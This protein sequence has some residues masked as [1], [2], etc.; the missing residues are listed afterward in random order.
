MEPPVESK[1]IKPKKRLAK[2]LRIKKYIHEEKV[3]DIKK[4]KERKEK[5]KALQALLK[6][7]KAAHKPDG[8]VE[9]KKRRIAAAER[10]FVELGRIVVLKFGKHAGTAAMIVDIVDQ[11]WVMVDGGIFNQKEQGLAC[12]RKVVNLKDLELTPLQTKITYRANL[13]VLKRLVAK[14]KLEEKWK[15][16]AKFQKL[17]KRRFKKN[18]TDLERWR[19]ALN[20]KQRSYLITTKYFK[21]KRKVCAHALKLY[22]P[23][24]P[25][26]YKDRPHPGCPLKKP[27]APRTNKKG[28]VIPKKEHYRSKLTG[29]E[30]RKIKKAKFDYKAIYDGRYEAR[31][32]SV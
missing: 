9:P 15:K 2:R 19:V 30:K 32:T 17:E 22:S 23:K 31:T 16:S 29:P 28:E 3:R 13:G 18:S 26:P 1:E 20:H 21:L 8:P 14:H 27:K 7:K 10:K 24:N 12:K 25:I 5:R 11:N 4:A 6:D